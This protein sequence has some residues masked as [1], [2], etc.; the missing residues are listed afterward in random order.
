MQAIA[1]MWR[2]GDEDHSALQPVGWRQSSGE[3][4]RADNM[5]EV[6]LELVLMRDYEFVP[7]GRVAMVVIH[8][9]KGGFWSQSFGHLSLPA[10][11]LIPHLI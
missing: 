7:G 5:E 11:G 6:R 2:Y 9:E 8:A 4:G 1:R 10:G 3:E